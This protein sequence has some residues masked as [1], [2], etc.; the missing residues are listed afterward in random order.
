MPPSLVPPSLMP[1]SL[2]PPSVLPPSQ[3]APTALPPSVAAD[4]T[5]EQLAQ[6]I[7]TLAVRL[8]HAAKASHIGSCLSMADILAVL[9]GGLLRVDPADP[10]WEERD[11]FILSKGH[12]AAILYSTLAEVGFF[13]PEELDTYCVAGSRLTGHVSHHVPG[14]EIST[15]SLGHG[16]SFGCGMALAAHR[17]RSPW[18]VFVLLSDGELDEGSNWEPILFAAHHG[19]ENLVAVVDYNKIQSF[20]SVEEVLGLEPL[21]DK[22]TAFGWGVREVDGHD[23]QQ[24]KSALAQI[25]FVPGRPSVLIA[26]TVKGKGVGFMENSLAWHYKSPSDEQLAQ[27]INELG[28]KR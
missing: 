1:P 7:R 11:R 14:V 17:G 8:V 22:W 28:C 19:L 9:Y 15:G 18:R 21:Q 23:H 12:A 10:T 25:P 16:L 5:T 20:G 27:A 13:A 4:T 2:M 3:V 24:I 6:R 26:H